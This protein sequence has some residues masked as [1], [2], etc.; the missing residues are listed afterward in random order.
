MPPH[1]DEKRQPDEQR[2]ILVA[3]IGEDTERPQLSLGRGEPGFLEQ[4][5][6]GRSGQAL[7]RFNDS[8]RDVPARRTCLDAEQC[9]HAVADKFIDDAAGGAGDQDP[10]QR[11]A[12]HTAELM[13]ALFDQPVTSDGRLALRVAVETADAL[14]RLAFRDDPGGDP[15]LLREA[16]VV[17]RGYLTVY[18]D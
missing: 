10:S 11:L 5:A 6:A 3:A 14:V 8:L 18:F 4:F 2:E 12:D 9:H 13:A 7:A 1:G 15:M 17:V 16:R